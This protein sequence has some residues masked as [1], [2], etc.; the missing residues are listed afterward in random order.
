MANVLKALTSAFKKSHVAPVDSRGGWWPWIREPYSG[1][2]Q[3]NEDWSVSSVLEH[4]VVYRCI[5]LISSDI[6][7]LRIGLMQRDKDGI[8]TWANSASVN[9]LLRKPNRYQNHIQFKESWMISK[10]I[11][12]NT[13]VLKQRD[14]RGNTGALYVLD[15]SRVQVLVAQ[16]GSVFYQL[17]QDSLVGQES[18]SVTVPASEIIHDR[19][20]CFFHPMVGISPLFAAGMSA[21]QGL[22]IIND[23]AKFFDNGARPSG[24]LSAPGAISDETAG[25]MKAHWDANY[26]GDNA[27]KVA[28]LGDGLKFE[29][30][31]MTS[32]DAQLVE[33]MHSS[34]ESICT[35]FGVPAYKVG[36]GQMPTHDNIDA[37]T[38]DY[39]SQ[40]LQ[41]HIESMEA[42]LDEG[43]DVPANQRTELDL[44]GL[45]RMDSGK[46]IETL[47]AGV[48]GS[49][50]TPNEGRKRI[51]LKPLTGGD[52]VYMQHQDYSIQALAW[53][54]AQ[55]NPF[56]P[57]PTTQPAPAGT[58]QDSEDQMRMLAL[59]VEKELRQ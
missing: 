55:P 31:R 34:D 1:A 9:A 41:V 48:R 43:L 52:T 12:G 39:Y 13:Y 2:W 37:L 29:P 21:T 26:T 10:L 46:Q 17:S 24:I 7:K 38:Q 5:G 6:G 44:N 59:L 23:S 45:I 40:C 58:E 33:Q 32:V 47:V 35:A 22:R 56:D 50:Y 49:V 57:T 14:A 20:N 15:P 42:G 27:G 16:D 36:V 30:M 18:T 8:W 53:R 11:R 28:V 51:N 19:M 4:P 3:N 25:R 54:D